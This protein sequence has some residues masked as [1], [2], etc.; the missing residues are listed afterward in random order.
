MHAYMRHERESQK[1][2][3]GTEREKMTHFSAKN[4]D[5]HK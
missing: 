2:F 5:Y 4:T 1:L 3:H